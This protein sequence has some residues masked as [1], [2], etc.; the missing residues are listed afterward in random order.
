[1]NNKEEE[2]KLIPIIEKADDYED[3]LKDAYTEMNKYA[4]LEG[5]MCIRDRIYLCPK[6]KKR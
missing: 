2:E 4:P 6:N 3:F 5:K 1:M